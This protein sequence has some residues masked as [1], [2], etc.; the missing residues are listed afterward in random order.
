[1]PRHKFADTRDRIESAAIRLFV[2]KGVAETSVRD[3]A[4]EV[5]IS[6]GALYRHFVSK[7]ELVWMAFERHYVEFADRLGSLAA[8]E[9]T[10]R[11][12]VAAMI[13]GFCQAHDEDP[14]LFRF[15]L[16]VQHGQLGKLASDTPTPVTVMREVVEAGI[17]SG[18]L[19]PQH[20]ALATALVFGVVLQPVTFAAYGQLPSG[21]GPLCDRLVAAAWAAITTV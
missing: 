13:R 20:P 2:D 5:D 18:E 19:P 6:E 11:G 8:G 4:R 16:F 15:L 14:T 3:I 10:S 12:K 17:A 21:M 1:M 7:D 9:T